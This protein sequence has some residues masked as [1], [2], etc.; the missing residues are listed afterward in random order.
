MDICKIVVFI[1]REFSEELMDS[2]T[3]SIDPPYDNYERVFSVSEVRGT[4][5]P[6]GNAKP[7]KGTIGEIEEADELRIE[8]II[9]KKDLAV[10]VQTI[11]RVHP[12]E[13]PAIDI[14][15]MTDW[16]SLL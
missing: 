11:C 14:I 7:F 3:G 13:E 12:Y 15:E 10:T 6:T 16:H 5:R 9:R 4:W 8:F 2:V 1:P